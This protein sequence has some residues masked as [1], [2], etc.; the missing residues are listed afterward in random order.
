MV[1]PLRSRPE[2]RA[3]VEKGGG[4]WRLINDLDRLDGLL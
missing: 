2:W 1:H 4:H 3:R